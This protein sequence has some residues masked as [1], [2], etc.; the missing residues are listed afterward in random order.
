MLLAPPV[1]M[2]ALANQ[3]LRAD[4]DLVAAPALVVK[5]VLLA[6]MAPMAKPA[7]P[8]TLVQTGRTVHQDPRDLRDLVV[9]QASPAKM[10]LLDV[11]VSPV[12]PVS[13][14]QEVLL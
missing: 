11:L 2:V 1:T 12:L 8:V 14:V 6:R 7:L 10:V 4:K 13:R 3:V 9:F 5:L